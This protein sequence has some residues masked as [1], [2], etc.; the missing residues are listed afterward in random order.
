MGKYIGYA[1]I[2]TAEQSEHSLDNQIKYL[3]IQ[4]KKLSLQF[5]GY[6]EKLSGK[7]RNRPI[8]MSIIE[9]LQEGDILGVYDNSRLGRNTEENLKIVNDVNTKGAKLQVNGKIIDIGNPNDKLM[10][11]IESAVSTYQRENQN[12][13]SKIGMESVKESGEW[14]FSSRTHGYHLLGTKRKPLVKINED[15]AHIIRIIFQEYSKGTSLIRVAKDLNK[16]G[17]RT[18]S[19]AKWIASTVRGIILNPLYMGYYKI[20][21]T[22]KSA[23]SGGSK[24]NVEKSNLV[25]SKFYTPIVSEELWWECYNS[26]RK[27]KRYHQ[28]QFEYRYSHYELSSVIRCSHCNSTYVHTF[29]KSRETVYEYYSAT[30]CDNECPRKRKAYAVRIIEPLFQNLYFMSFLWMEDV[31]QY[32]NLIEYEFKQVNSGN[33]K[34]TDRILELI[35]TLSTRIANLYEGIERGLDF[36]KIIP[37]IQNLEREKSEL[38]DRF[39][40]LQ[41]QVLSK[42]QE[43]DIL[44][45]NYS[46]NAIE[47]FILGNSEQRRNAYLSMIEAFSEDD[48]ITVKYK[49]GMKIVIPT[50]RNHRWYIQTVFDLNIY[51]HDKYFTTLQFDT[52]SERFFIYDEE[53]NKHEYLNNLLKSLNEKKDLAKSLSN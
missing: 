48:K 44:L 18:K 12:L 24:F 43:L 8:L 29:T 46:E 14:I 4:A 3:N 49:T 50:K 40:E 22:D 53:K 33:L 21:T 26:F 30:H 2:S 28:K 41:T 34:E 9:Q 36:D 32:L 6:K 47:R 27:I 52:E 19:N 45:D 31:E 7:D 10:L 17:Y 42:E 16:Q 39:K 20:T 1:R 5:T 25:K 38:E 35:K 23:G 51:R 15:E 37:R 13:K 11:T